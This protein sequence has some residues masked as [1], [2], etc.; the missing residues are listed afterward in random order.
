M[1][2]NITL[3]PSDQEEKWGKPSP[4]GEVNRIAAILAQAGKTAR[5]T[6]AAKAATNNKDTG[7]KQNLRTLLPTLDLAVLQ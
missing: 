2:N 3:S 5:A 1:L 4:R 7:V 6:T